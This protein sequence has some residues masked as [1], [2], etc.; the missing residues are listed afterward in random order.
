M[1]NVRVFCIPISQIP[2]SPARRKVRAAPK[3]LS[4][5]RPAFCR[6]IGVN[7]R[8]GVGRTSVAA[9]KPQS[10]APGSPTTASEQ[11]HP[12]KPG[13]RVCRQFGCCCTRESCSHPRITANS[14]DRA[15]QVLEKAQRVGS[16]GSSSRICW[17]HLPRAGGFGEKQPGNFATRISKEIAKNP[18]TGYG[19]C[20]AEAEAVFSAARLFV[21]DDLQNFHDKNMASDPHYAIAR[22]LL[23]LGEAVAQLRE[24]AGLTRSELGR[25]LRVKARDI[26]VVEEETP[27]APAGL[28]EAALSL[29]MHEI[30]PRMQQRSEVSMSMRRIRQLRPALVPA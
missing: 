29:L 9:R 30:T 8:I 25:Q 4:G 11:D 18:A 10:R 23:D 17:K 27:R 13:R 19:N 5:V 14:A 26:A 21:K 7:P 16:L 28:L 22:Q 20:S 24:Q 6:A 2:R 3:L 15:E 12:L 1:G